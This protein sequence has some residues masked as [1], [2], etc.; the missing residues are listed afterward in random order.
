MQRQAV[1]IGPQAA[2]PAA[3]C[4]AEAHFARDIRAGKVDQPV[5][6]GP[7]QIDPRLIKWPVKQGQPFYVKPRGE[8]VI[9]PARRRLDPLE[10]PLPCAE[11]QFIKLALQRDIAVAV[12][13]R[14]LAPE[15]DVDPRDLRFLAAR[16]QDLGGQGVGVAN[17]DLFHPGV[18]QAGLDEQRPPPARGLAERG[19]QGDA[20]AFQVA[21]D[22]K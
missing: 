5:S 17:I 22:L 2:S 3:C 8:A 14:G 16:H 13:R 10:N 19:G 1:E 12:E 6:P 20:G 18:G 7:G 21:A 9:P 11:V 15:A 4:L